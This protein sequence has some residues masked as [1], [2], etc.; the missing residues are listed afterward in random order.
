MLNY[1][2]RYLKISCNLQIDGYK[3]VAI[4]IYGLF[5][6]FTLQKGIII[7]STIFH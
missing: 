1:L 2:F 5:S 7:E 4:D 6:R 3:A